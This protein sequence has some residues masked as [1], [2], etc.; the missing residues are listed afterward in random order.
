[1]DI[2]ITMC[3]EHHAEPLKKLLKSNWVSPDA[4]IDY[5]VDTA[6][7]KDNHRGDCLRV[8]FI[9]EGNKP[10]LVALGFCNYNFYYKYYKTDTYMKADDFIETY[11]LGGVE[12]GELQVQ[13][14]DT[15]RFRVGDKRQLMNKEIVEIIAVDKAE[16]FPIEIRYS[17]GNYGIRTAEGKF[18]P[19]G[20]YCPLDIEIY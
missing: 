3:R 5:K 14:L 4:H 1:M 11:T 15:P 7:N 6:C 16:P 10:S 17:D 12:S 20:G 18:T 8:K 13:E 2:I 19:K 9:K